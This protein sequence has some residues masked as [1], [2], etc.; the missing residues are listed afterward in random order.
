MKGKL[1]H[2]C[3]SGRRIPSLRKEAELE[4]G[5]SWFC[6]DTCP[7][8]RTKSRSHHNKVI[9]W[10]GL[11]GN[12]RQEFTQVRPLRW[13]LKPTSCFWCYWWWSRLQGCGIG[14]LALEDSKLVLCTSGASLLYIGWGLEITTESG[15]YCNP[16]PSLIP[17][18]LVIQGGK[19]LMFSM[20]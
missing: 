11:I 12:E 3:P 9:A 19:L 7:R 6:H 8:D 13:M 16:W 2:K 14:D 17:T 20:K 15:S 10:M 18:H 5:M 1:D 4:R